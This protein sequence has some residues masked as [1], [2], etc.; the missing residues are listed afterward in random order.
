MKAASTGASQSEAN[1]WLLLYVLQLS[2]LDY[3]HGIIQEIDKFLILIVEVLIYSDVQIF[4]SDYK[5]NVFALSFWEK[6][7]WRHK[8]SE[9]SNQLTQQLEI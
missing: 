8:S 3:L 7:N 1:V 6:K 2:L 5:I 4:L 9:S